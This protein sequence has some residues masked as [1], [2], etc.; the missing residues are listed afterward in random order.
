MTDSIIWEDI[1]ECLELY[2]CDTALYLFL[3]LSHAF[4]TVIDW[5]IG[6]PGHR[7]SF[8]WIEFSGQVILDN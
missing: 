7:N 2:I 1:D 8:I 5:L 4:Q 6:I 3:L